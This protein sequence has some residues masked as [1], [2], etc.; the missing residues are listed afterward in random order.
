MRTSILTAVLVLTLAVITFTTRGSSAQLGE[1]FGFSSDDSGGS[2]YLGV[3]TRDVTTDRMADLKL[4]EEHGVEITMVDQDA[5]AGKA[6]LKERDVILTVN[7]TQVESVEQLR[8]MIR[9]IP[10]GRMVTLGI[11]RDGQPMTI[12][13]QLASRKSAFAL[14][15]DGKA[16]KF[17]MPAM[18]AMPAIPALPDMDIP[19]S[20]VVVHSSARS[21]LMVENLTPQ[22]ADFFGA[23]QG[24]GILVRSVDKGSRAE[25]AGFRAGDVIVRVEGASIDD[26]SDFTHALHN[27]KGNKDNTVRIGIIRDKKEQT[28]TLTLPEHKQSEVIDQTLELPDIDLETRI[29]LREAADEIARIKPELE[30]SAQEVRRFKTAEIERLGP[31]IEQSTRELREHEEELKKEIQ[32]LQREFCNSSSEI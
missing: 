14:A 17:A 12:K 23:K 4:K 18:P 26:T 9:E 20:V 16:F 11:S 7:G 21:G 1:T 8:R 13:A 31:E 15:N 3:D 10:P 19:V 2:S 28:V 29:D 5:P 27:R 30:R 25:K 6:G 32:E 24:K 22:L